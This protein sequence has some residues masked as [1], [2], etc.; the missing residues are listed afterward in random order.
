MRL[1][2]SVLVPCLSGRGFTSRYDFILSQR[3]KKKSL[4][5]VRLHDPLKDYVLNISPLHIYVY[6]LLSFS[7]AKH[8]FS[9]M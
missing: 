4:F 3:E 9:Y 7:F 6:F 1:S 2:L 5:L 8:Y